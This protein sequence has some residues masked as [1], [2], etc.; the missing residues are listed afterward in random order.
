MAGT[1]VQP[2]TANAEFPAVSPATIA[3]LQN[4]MQVYQTTA[5]R[6]AEKLTAA[7]QALSE[8]KTPLEFVELQQKLLTDCVADTISD[9][10][11]IGRL[12]TDA[13]AA[14]FKSAREQMDAV[15]VS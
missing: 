13:F 8:A 3:G 9:G 5:Q 11:D 15:K 4:L 10:A 1:V 7:M 6:N 14:S 12:A 2:T